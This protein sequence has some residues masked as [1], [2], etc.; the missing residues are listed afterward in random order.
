MGLVILGAIALYLIVSLVVVVLAAKVAK[1]QGRSPWRW[2]GAAAL[3]MYLLVFWDHIPTVV[4]H[5]Y[6]CKKEAGFWVYKTVEQWKA[7]NPGM[8]ETLVAYNDGRSANGA[9]ILNQRFNRAV[10]KGGPLLFNR[11]RWEQQIVDSKTNEILARYVDFSTGNGNIGGEPPVRFW[12][13]NDYCSGGE[14]N[15]GLM[16]SFADGVRGRTK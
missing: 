5:K 6:Y 12:L 2:G 15:K 9:Y 11:W 3:V 10:K 4:A 7:Q 14:Y 1:K 8:M 16:Y 13:Q